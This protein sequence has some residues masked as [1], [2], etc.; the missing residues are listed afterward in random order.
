MPNPDLFC[1]SP[2]VR[3]RPRFT[4]LASL[5]VPLAL[6]PSCDGDPVELPPRVP[7]GPTT[8]G[9]SIP[10]GFEDWAVLGV[11]NRLDNGSVRVITGNSTAVQAARAGNTNPWPDGS[12]I[13]DLVWTGGANPDWVDMVGATDFGALAFMFKNAAAYADDYGWKYGIWKGLDLTAPPEADF[14]RDCV[15]CHID[16]ALENDSVFTRIMPLPDI[17][18]TPEPSPNGIEAPTGWQDWAVIGVADRTDNGTIRVI[19]GN[20]IAVDAARNGTLPWPDGSKIAD[21]VW[22]DGTNPDWEMMNGA[23]EFRTMIYMIKDSAQYPDAGGWAYGQWLGADMTP[24]DPG[25]DVDCIQC[26]LDEAPE[27]DYVFTRSNYLP[28]T[29]PPVSQ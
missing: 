28:R 10:N 16:E 17:N 3:R 22:A 19:T 5:L 1:D 6:A 14:D 11:A 23:G 24:A 25:F 13:A 9:L 2:V 15:Q 7:G 4:L 12:Q 20:S 26:H 8:N 29:P 18:L 21:L 27:N